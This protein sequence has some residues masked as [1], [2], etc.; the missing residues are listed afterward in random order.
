MTKYKIA[1]MGPN[2]EV[3][4]YWRNFADGTVRVFDSAKTAFAF[5]EMWQFVGRVVPCD[6]RT[7]SM[8]A[9]ELAQRW[10]IGLPGSTDN[11]PDAQEAKAM[12]ARCH[13][14]TGF[15]SPGCENGEYGFSAMTPAQKKFWAAKINAWFS[16]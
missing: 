2:K 13:Q 16:L 7:Y 4:G 12:V 11:P 14:E 6:A 10:A 5:I 15:G 1:V 8:N 9:K 3:I